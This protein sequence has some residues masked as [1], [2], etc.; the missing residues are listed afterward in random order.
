MNRFF[1]YGTLKVGGKFAE[2]FDDYRLTST[3]AVLKGHDLYNLGW[4]P[5]IKEGTGKVHGEL[6][7]YDNVGF[8]TKELD[9]IEGF[10]KLSESGSLFVRKRL[11]IET[12]DGVVEA[13]VY[14]FNR[15][16]DKNCRLISD[17]IW[18]I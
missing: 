5:G 18:E 9:R 14:V 7:T 11:P 15:D 8:V 10:N 1:V 3:K 6:H 2:Y 17:G 12:D 4:F 13:N 16:L